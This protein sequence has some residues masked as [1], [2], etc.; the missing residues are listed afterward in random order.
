MSWR[1]KP[2]DNRTP[3]NHPLF[4]HLEWG[5][6]IDDERCAGD[7]NFEL[8]KPHKPHKPERSGPDPTPAPAGKPDPKPSA[9]TDDAGKPGR[10]TK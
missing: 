5:T 1:Y 2:R 8:I 10:S 6:V 7:P 3:V 4:G 9:D